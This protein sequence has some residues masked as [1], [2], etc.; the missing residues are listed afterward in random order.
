MLLE[1][2]AGMSSERGAAISLISLRVIAVPKLWKSCTSS[3]K[4][5]VP[6]TT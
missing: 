3:T 4:L 6:P 5:P 1:R 2:E